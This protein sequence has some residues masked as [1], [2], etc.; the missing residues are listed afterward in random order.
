MPLLNIPTRAGKQEDKAIA[1]K[2]KTT[3]KKNTGVLDRIGVIKMT[4]DKYLGKY[5]D[6]YIV[7]RDRETLVNYIDKCIEND[8]ISIDTETTGLDVF[9]D[10]LVGLCIYTPNMP[11]A[12]IPVNHKSYITLELLDNQLSIDVLHEQFD[13]LA[14]EDTKVIMFNANF[15][16]RV[17][18]HFINVYLTCYWDCY[19]ASRLLNENE[20]VGGKGLKALHKKYILDGK[21]DEFSYEAIF[22]GTSFDIVPIDYAYLYAAHD[23]IVTYEL[24][25]FQKQYLSLDNPREDMRKLAEVF[26]NIEMPCVE[27]VCDMGDN[28]VTF[29]METNRELAKKYEPLLQEKLDEFNHALEEY[30]DKIDIYMASH[31]NHGLV[32]PISVRSPSQLATLFY[33]I[34]QIK[35]IDDKKPRGTG[36]EIM[37][38]I[39]LP[40]AKVILEYR[41]FAKTV[42][43]YINKLPTWVKKDGKIHC[44]FNQYGADTGRMSSEDPNLQNIPH[45]NMR[46]MFTS[47]VLSEEVINKY[48][49]SQNEYFEIDK[50]HKVETIN[51]FVFAK[52]II[53]GDKLKIKNDDV[54]DVITVSKIET[55]VDNNHILLYY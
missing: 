22:R 32:T 41:E 53:V 3:I 47:T 17:L 35:P 36:E 37:K 23:A 2:S 29:N 52:D 49:V 34:L 21:E 30:Q 6:E 11:A 19:L 12:Y 46:T 39:D 8:V 10:S 43:T 31:P 50:R 54:D 5:K 33:D 44:V 18:R 27:V 16:I 20:G 55:L 40:I 28:G 24:Y 25:E 26:F 48:D 51:G 38:K 15:D 9:D 4:V 13:R 7:I 14:K 1:Q 45:N 42:D